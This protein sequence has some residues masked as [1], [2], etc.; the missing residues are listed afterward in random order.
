MQNPIPR[1]GWMSVLVKLYPFHRKQWSGSSRT[2]KRKT[3]IYGRIQK[4]WNFLSSKSSKSFLCQLKQPPSF[5]LLKH[6]TVFLLCLKESPCK[7]KPV[8]LAQHPVLSPEMMSYIPACPQRKG[9]GKLNP[10]RIRIWGQHYFRSFLILLTNLGERCAG[11][12][13]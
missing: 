8:L 12:D 10:G 5:S 13:F 7:G 1:I 4:P 11:I 3:E 2:Q 6:F 9:S